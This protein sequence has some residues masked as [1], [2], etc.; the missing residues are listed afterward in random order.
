MSNGTNGKKPPTY[1][2]YP[3]LYG[4]LLAFTILIGG[5]GWALLMDLKADIRADYSD[6]KA[7]IRSLRTNK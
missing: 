6:I 5:A 2:T 4:V 1:V 7:E 3:A